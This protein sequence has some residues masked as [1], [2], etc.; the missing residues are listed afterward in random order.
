MSAPLV[1]ADPP[2]SV[3]PALFT[4]E[5][6]IPPRRI[7][8]AYRCGLGLT[9]LAMLL[10][11]L[12]YLGIIGATA[13][14]VF[15]YTRAA[16]GWLRADAN[17]T[18]LHTLFCLSPVV[19]GAILIVFMIKPLF[20]GSARAAVPATLD[21]A[22][23]PQLQTLIAAV[24]AKVGAPMPVRVD[25]DC[26]INASARLR[27][28]L[29]S[30][31]RNDLVLTI[32]LPLVAGLDARQFAGVLAHEFG[33]FSQ[34]AG[35]AFTYVIR[36]ITGWFARVVFE[37]D[38]WDEGL[39][40]LTRRLD[41]RIA[42]VL[43][44]ARAAVWLTRKLLHGLMQIGHA[45]ACLQLRQMEFDADYYETH[46]AGSRA[47]ASTSRELQRLNLA[48]NVA[49]NEL[50]EL[51]RD[52]R[53]VDDYPGYVVRRRT[54]LTREIDER[55]KETESLEQ[56]RW[57]HTHPSNTARENHALSLR[58]PGL[59]QGEAPASAL[60]HQ[61]DELCR[62][63]TVHYYREGLELDFEP[64]TLLSTTAA[65]RTGDR[66]AT[67]SAAYQRIFG[68]GAL[69]LERPLLW[70]EEDFAAPPPSHDPAAIVQFLAGLRAEIDRLR[71][72]AVAAEARLGELRARWLQARAGREFMLAK[73]D[74][75]PRAF[76]LPSAVFAEFNA[77]IAALGQQLASPPAE[78][79][80]YE[81][82]IHRW[83][84]TVVATARL[85]HDSLP[86][87]LVAGLNDTARCLTAFLPWLRPFPEWAAEQRIFECSLEHE[88]LLDQQRNYTLLGQQCEKLRSLANYA[89]TL[90]A[91]LAWPLAPA[92]TPR[93]AAEQLLRALE[94]QPPAQHLTILLRLIAELYFHSLGQL[95]AQ[96][97][98]LERI[99]GESELA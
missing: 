1:A 77:H 28:G 7:P 87:P 61:F 23:Q 82:A 9:A 2:S 60:F 83:G 38:T 39:A 36:S 51:W 45:I 90:V 49:F 84:A 27:R 44:A 17:H 43:W 57:F 41:F 13:Y 30:L 80:A 78:I 20:A 18:V 15:N 70:R 33:H 71:P 16:L 75:D 6:S 21:L 40:E 74:I 59:F 22:Q 65:A 5:G 94:H 42:V 72:A 98:E 35:M 86:A 56:S 91:N 24:C 89:P 53:L 67:G 48:G 14:G 58:Q 79:A 54:H 32:G 81:A 4:L 3:A 47:F 25:V 63:A 66:A 88:R 8:L 19:I 62:E 85:Y 50:G 96:G 31:G 93:T 95:A 34:G 52:K 12:V 76:G 37:R 10:L 11:P 92:H 99:L 68:P 64:G 97:E 55:L 69:N 46:V 26:D 73:V 29:L